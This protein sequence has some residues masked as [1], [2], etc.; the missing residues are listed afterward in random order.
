MSS[1]KAWWSIFQKVLSHAWC[2]FFAFFLRLVL[3]LQASR[4]QLAYLEELGL[5]EEFLI[6]P[7]AIALGIGRTPRIIAFSR[8]VEFSRD[9]SLLDHA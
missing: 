8:I 5:Y 3:V 2:L 9:Y 4:K 6:P 1:K 7:S